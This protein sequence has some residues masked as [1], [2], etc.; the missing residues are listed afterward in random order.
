MGTTTA[1]TLETFAAHSSLVQPGGLG[2][3]TRILITPG[4]RWRW[5]DAMLTN[6]HLPR[7]TL[8]AMIAARLGEDERGA[9]R[10]VASYQEAIAAG[11][12]FYSFGDAMLLL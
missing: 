6:F 3:W 10:L 5:V 12:R 7:S 1:R 8:M 2:A 9:A 4:Y 11:Y